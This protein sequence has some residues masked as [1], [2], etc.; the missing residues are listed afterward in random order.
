[1]HSPELQEVKCCPK[2]EMYI[3]SVEGHVIHATWEGYEFDPG[4]TIN[5]EGKW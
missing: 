3:G 2:S 5:S 1:M 4:E